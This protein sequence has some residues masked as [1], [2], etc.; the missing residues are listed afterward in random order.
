MEAGTMTVPGPVS[1]PGQARGVTRGP[2]LASPPGRPS[3]PTWADMAT[4]STVA[5]LAPGLRRAL[6]EAAR[7]PRLLVACDYDGTLAPIGPD[8]RAVFPLPEA[9]TALRTLGCL[10]DTT[11]AVISGRALR[12]L[13][14]LSRLPAEVHLIGS[15][16][17]EF[18]IGFVHT[19]DDQTQALHARLVA[20]LREITGPAP[21]VILEV[22]P[23]AVAVH[24]RQADQAVA[25]QVLAQVRLGP[26][27]RVR[28]GV[29]GRRRERGRGVRPAVRSRPGNQGRR[30]PNSGALP[31]RGRPRGGRRPVLPGRGAVRLAV[32]R[33]GVRHRAAIHA[34]ERLVGGAGHARR[35]GV[36]AVPSE[37]G[38]RA[39]VRRP[40]GRPPR[41]ALL[42][43][44]AA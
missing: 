33:S 9:V 23:A 13:A 31:H 39:G 29:R 7:K 22:K 25:R 20:A 24:V 43:P 8:P 44:A 34:G 6:T 28:G 37:P 21:G 38:I 1:A 18:D 19:L 41:R 16:G 3:I 5:S 17:S 12:E 2:E 32:R 4:R 15:H 36:L 27:Q 42:H 35:P 30:W 26:G 14:V 40:A 11:A 10:P